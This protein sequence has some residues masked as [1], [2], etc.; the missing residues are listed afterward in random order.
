MA[1]GDANNLRRPYPNG[2]DS[3]AIIQSG[4]LV[5]AAA[6]AL[7]A[8]RWCELTVP[9]KCRVVHAERTAG[10]VTDADADGVLTV[11]DDSGTPKVV[12]PSQAITA[13]AAGVAT[14]K[15]LTIDPSLVLNAGALLRF[16]ATTGDA[17]DQIVGLVVT[18]W[19]V[20]ATV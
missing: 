10:L 8:Y 7:T 11:F 18:L 13:L 15:T 19:V 20:P 2:A 17:G 9:F 4:P 6:A 5:Q 14:A 12:V 3:I 1:G 16:E